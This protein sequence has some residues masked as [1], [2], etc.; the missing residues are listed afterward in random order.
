M[1]DLKNCKH[2]V[3]FVKSS[4]WK[5]NQQKRKWIKNAI[6]ENWNF[7]YVVKKFA[8]INIL[9]NIKKKI[10]NKN[11]KETKMT[12]NLTMKKQQKIIFQTL[13]LLIWQIWNHLNMRVY[14]LTKRS[15]IF[16]KKAWYTIKIVMI[17]LHMIWINS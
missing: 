2:I 1:H 13:N 15:T 14:L 5:Y 8:N 11:R 7:Y 17:H 3:K 4:N 6:K 12:R 10:A 9:N 16:Y